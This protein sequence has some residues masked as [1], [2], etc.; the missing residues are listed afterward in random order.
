MDN[1]NE[2]QNNGI[3][4][5]SAAAVFAAIIADGK[6]PYEQNILAQ[7]FTA[8]SQNLLSIA[9]IVFSCKSIQENIHQQQKAIKPQ[10]SK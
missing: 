6:T 4:I 2:C 1:K 5:V 9:S 10:K 3:D 7:F 8:L